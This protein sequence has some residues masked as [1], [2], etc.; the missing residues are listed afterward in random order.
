MSNIFLRIDGVTGESNAMGHE[1]E[2]VLFSWEWRLSQNVR[3]TSKTK[4]ATI[5]N[6]RCV[7]RVSLASNGLMSMLLH[8][9]CAEKAVLSLR[10]PEAQATA[11]G[12][13]GRLVPPPDYMKI[14]LKN[15]MVHDL[16]P[17]GSAYGHFEEVILSFSEFTTEY[18][19]T[20]AGRLAGVSS[21]NYKIGNA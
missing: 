10:S 19:P 20:I 3:D 15:V 8:S 12:L 1:G 21:V 4:K 6:I 5:N 16:K 17:Y 7:H 13:V 9:K 11:Q 18:T 2:I 14:K